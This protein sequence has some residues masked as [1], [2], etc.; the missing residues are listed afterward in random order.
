MEGT[1]LSDCT[2]DGVGGVT[3]MRGAIVTSRDAI[4][5]AYTLASALGIRIED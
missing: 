5:L 4:G 1:R 3:S 2:L